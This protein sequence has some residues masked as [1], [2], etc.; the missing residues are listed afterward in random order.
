MIKTDLADDA[1]M[2][3]LPILVIE[4]LTSCA[5]YKFL[6]KVCEAPRQNHLNP[7]LSTATRVPQ[8]A[9]HRVNQIPWHVT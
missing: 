4:S 7:P 2:S 5:F 9:P 6:C 3:G 1:T 8:Q